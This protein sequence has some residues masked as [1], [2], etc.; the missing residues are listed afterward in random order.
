MFTYIVITRAG[1]ESTFVSS[2]SLIERLSSGELDEQFV[3]F[4]DK[5]GVETA[6]PAD[7]IAC[8]YCTPYWKD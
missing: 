8:I 2:R 7:D 1:V 3:A 4:T 5:E 6:L